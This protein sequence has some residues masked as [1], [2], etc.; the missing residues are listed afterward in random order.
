MN[1]VKKPSILFIMPY[2]GKWPDWFPAFL[3]SCKLN[4]DI[5]WLIPTDCM[6]PDDSPSNV[7]FVESTL[8]KLRT[9]T[10][11]VTGLNVIMDRAYKTCDIRPAFAHIFS[12]EVKNYDFWGHCDMDIIFGKIRNF[13]TV[14]LLNKYDIITTRKERIAG[15]FTLYRNRDDINCL[16]KK[17]SDYE[18]V[19]TSEG[20]YHYDENRMTEVIKSELKSG[21]DLKVYWP[22]FLLNYRVPRD[23]PSIVPKSL[24]KW[25]WSNGKLYD[26][27]KDGGEIMYFHFMTWKKTL[28]YCLFNYDD[29]PPEFY[30]S[31]THVSIKKSP[32][33]AK[34]MSIDISKIFP[35]LFS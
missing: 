16:Y 19:F 9:T 8:E 18:M 15:H 25:R 7:K 17:H 27:G 20:N 28:K 2:Y 4:P 21:A 23:K 13:M 29:N 22:N 24:N 32:L 34:F 5:D 31:Y 6:I 1:S 33:P 11:K 26:E 14:D 30:I 10:S 12:E 35:R 3:L